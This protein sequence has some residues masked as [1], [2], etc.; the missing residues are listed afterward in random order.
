MKTDLKTFERELDSQMALL[1]RADH[2]QPDERCLERVKHGVA[3]EA[4]LFGPAR[5]GLALDRT[6]VWSTAAALV[7]AAGL[8]WQMSSLESGPLPSETPMSLASLTHAI[9]AS[10]DAVAMLVDDG[11]IPAGADAEGRSVED[12]LD[13]LLDTLDSALN[14]DA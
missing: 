11:W 4:R 3:V 7:L 6:R 1:S 10:T 14:L 2:P 12:V 13:D 5:S 8:A 9:D